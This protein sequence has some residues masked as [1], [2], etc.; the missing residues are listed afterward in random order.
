MIE[1]LPYGEFIARYDRPGALIYLDP[2]YWGSEDDYGK[3]MFEPGDFARLADQLRGIKGR[4]LMSINDV[5]EVR[6]LFAGFDLQEVS[7][8]YTVGKKSG[9]R[10]QRSEL[11]VSGGG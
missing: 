1:C 8:S 6:E 9:S 2:P 7:T 5:P 3:A 10:G 4:F 11:L